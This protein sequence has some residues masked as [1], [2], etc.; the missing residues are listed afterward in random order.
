MPG[1]LY[2]L[3]TVFAWGTWLTPSQNIPFR[4]QQI[5]TFYVAAANLA[6][7]LLVLLVRGAEG[8]TWAVFWS[9]FL[10]GLVWAVSG[11]L[12]FTGTNRLGMARAFGIWAPVNVLVSILWGVL[13]FGELIHDGPQRLALFALALVIALAGVLLIIF[14]KG[15]RASGPADPHARAGI[16][17]ALGAGVLWGSYFIPVQLSA[18]S[19]WVAAFPLAVGI[20][21]GSAFLATFTRQPLRL[22]R[23]SH[24]ARVLSTGLLWGIGNYGMLLLVSEFGA[25]RGFTISQLGI[26]VNGLMGVYLLKDPPPRSRA[27]AL[28]LIGCVL[29][30]LGG[31]LMG[32]GR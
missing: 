22:E 12:A 13:L 32:G 3:I 5:K 1:I 26:V 30:T 8:L 17:A 29:A 27:A 16:L 23:P 14:A 7:A 28:T 2:A 9:P 11:F 31:I 21:V 20:F 24:Y 18:A 10:G 15:L 25:G 6:L 4:N 19:M